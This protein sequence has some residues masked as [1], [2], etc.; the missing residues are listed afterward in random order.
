MQALVQL[1]E[2]EH[3]H[4]VNRALHFWVGMPLVGLGFFLFVRLEWRGVVPFALG[5]GAMFFGH[6]AFER[7]PPTVV[8]DPL[9]PLAAGAFVIDRL[10]MRPLR[11]LRG[12]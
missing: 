12:R 6:Y 2:A 8:R 9:G 4:P 7:R 3:Q 5:Y 1:F 11:R 10:C